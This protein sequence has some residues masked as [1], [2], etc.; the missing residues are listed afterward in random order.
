MTTTMTHHSTARPVV[1]PVSIVDFRWRF[2]MLTAGLI[3]ILVA[4]AGADSLVDFTGE[5]WAPD[6]AGLRPPS[7]GPGRATAKGTADGVVPASL[8]AVS[9][10]GN[11]SFPFN[12]GE[13]TDP[14]KRIQQVY[15]GS[16]VG[17]GLITHLI[18]RQDEG[19][20]HPF[21]PV[22]IPG[23]TITMSTITA[24]PDQ[25]VTAFA[26]NVGADATVVLEGEL[27][28]SSNQSLAD[29]RP[30]DIS[31]ELETPFP[32]VGNAGANLLV[33]VR[34]DNC[35]LAHTTP[36]DSE[37]TDGDS[38]SRVFSYNH[39]DYP[40]GI[41]DTRGLVTRFVV[42]GGDAV[43]VNGFEAGGLGAWSVVVH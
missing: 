42:Q 29:P 11:N 4:G 18:F 39:A 31:I 10:N 28:L 37:T 8:A 30:W 23:V 16:E 32:F 14:S 21:T 41:T 27:T 2:L 24:G 5:G 25:L 36:F 12:C 22:T 26:D 20:G 6:T 33:D 38:V 7:E 9:G 13:F 17:A 3:L 1:T 35:S 15:L 34:V 19:I 40:Y 43:F